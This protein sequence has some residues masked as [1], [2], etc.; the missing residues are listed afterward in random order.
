MFCALGRPGEGPYVGLLTSVHKFVFDRVLTSVV[1]ISVIG[2]PPFVGV[3]GSRLLT[4][5]CYLVSV[6]CL[7]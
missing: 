1:L 6:C 5:L 4:H 2:F 3:S 7:I